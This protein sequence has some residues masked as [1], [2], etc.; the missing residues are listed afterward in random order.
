M[1]TVKFDHS[2]KYKGVRHP[3]HEFFVVDDA[4][5]EELKKDGAHVLSTTVSQPAPVVEPECEEST[6]DFI[7]E[8]PVDA[9]KE[10]DINAL[11]EELL[12][13]NLEHLIQFANEH[14]I[15]LQSKTRKADIYNLIVASFE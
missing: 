6:E 8:E 12:G 1:T 3:A 10:S 9:E 13:Y 4:D 5:M 14:D 15:D 2:V 11:R 7:N